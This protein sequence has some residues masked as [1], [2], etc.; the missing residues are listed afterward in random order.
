[1]ENNYE[2][3]RVGGMS[4]SYYGMKA[5]EK[6]WQ[7]RLGNYTVLFSGPWTPDKLREICDFCREKNIHFAMDEMI[8]RLDGD[9]KK[10]YLPFKDEILSV[11]SEYEDI[12]DGTLIM[13]EYG[14]LMFYWPQSTVAGSKT[15]A[16][17]I[18]NYAQGEEK[19]VQT[20]K[21]LLESAASDGVRPPFICIEACGAA[22]HFL[23]RA[24]IDRADLEVTYTSELERSYSAV[25]G[26]SLAFGKKHFGVDMAM[27][28]YGGNQHDYLWEKRWRTSLFHAF[29]RGADPIY[30]EHGIMDYRALGKNYDENHPEVARFRS[31]LGEFAE[32]AAAHPRPAGFPEAA[33]GVI[34]GRYDGFAGLGQTHLFGERENDA[35]RISDAERSWELFERFYRRSLWENRDRFGEADCSGNPPLGQADII[36]YDAPDELLKRYKALLF[37]GHNSMD[38]AL[39]QKLLRYVEGGGQLL[40]TAAHLDTSAAPQGEFEPYLDGDWSELFGVRFLRRSSA[41]PVYGIKFKAEPPFGWRFPLWS[42]NCDP[43]FTDGG[44]CTA[45][46]QN[47]GAE[48]LAVASDRFLDTEWADSMQG[49]LF[50]K[51]H[52]SGCAVL[53]N[54]LEYPGAHGVKNLYGFLMDACCEANRDYPKVECSDRVRYASYMTPEGRLLWLL[55]TEERLS[56]AV[57][58]YLSDRESIP[59]VL[60]A[61]EIR[62]VRLF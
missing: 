16:G 45:E 54:S 31:V 21:K 58:I 22:A 33:V 47:A 28:W 29:I 4:E 35:F 24:G 52:G 46:L 10:N 51:R 7:E 2:P 26:A 36:P 12:F 15:A 13:C 30:A 48:V 61:G 14:G 25:K 20:L 37:L 18:S 19:T 49:A 6:L 1:M 62:E 55:N 11:L 23:Y 59:L 39:Y 41:K 43:K 5:A 42:P 32:F 27:V 34:Q 57:N 60:Q 40:M 9:I 44:F 56:Q 38:D 50:C 8:D 3:V 53:V 17:K